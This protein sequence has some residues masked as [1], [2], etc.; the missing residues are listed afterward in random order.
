MPEGIN[1]SLSF[2]EIQRMKFK[3][4][5]QVLEYSTPC[6][7]NCYQSLFFLLLAYQRKFKPRLI[8]NKTEEFLTS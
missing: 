6:I 2:N 7:S 3:S 1:T 4:F 8:D 5:Q